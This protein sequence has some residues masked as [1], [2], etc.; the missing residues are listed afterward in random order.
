MSK[1][2]TAGEWRALP[3]LVRRGDVIAVGIK[4]DVL[5]EVVVVVES[6][7]ALDAIPY[8]RIAGVRVGKQMRF[9]KE[10]VSRMLAKEY[11]N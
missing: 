11:R 9:V 8:G 6:E 4:R 10:T 7:A 2:I 3:P 5:A 1:M